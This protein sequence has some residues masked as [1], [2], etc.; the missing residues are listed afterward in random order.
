MFEVKLI[1]KGYTYIDVPDSALE[2]QDCLTLQQVYYWG[3]EA[4]PHGTKE[5]SLVGYWGLLPPRKRECP[6]C[7]QELQ[8]AS[9]P[10]FYASN[11][12]PHRDG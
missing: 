4:C 11:D 3:N 8:Q 10:N 1:E 9:K 7:W 6:I 5:L 2:A 12:Y